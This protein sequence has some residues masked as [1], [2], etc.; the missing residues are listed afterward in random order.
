[1]KRSLILLFPILFLFSSSTI[2]HAYD[3]EKQTPDSLATIWAPI[4]TLEEVNGKKCHGGASFYI[5]PG[6]NTIQLKHITS[7]DPVSNQYNIFTW[8]IKFLAEKGHT[9]YFYTDN[10]GQYWDTNHNLFG[11]DLGFGFDPP[12]PPLLFMTKEY[13]QVVDENKNKGTDIQVIE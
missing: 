6:E 2:S 4:V 3:G 9:Y 12:A 11:R 1:V 8:E 5:T 13:K 10:N 7:A